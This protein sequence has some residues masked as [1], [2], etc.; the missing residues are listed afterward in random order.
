MTVK[1]GWLKI[2]NSFTLTKQ[3]LPGDATTHTVEWEQV[4]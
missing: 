3:E 1:P 4:F 2:A